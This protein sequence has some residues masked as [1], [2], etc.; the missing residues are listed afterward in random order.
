MNFKTIPAAL[1]GKSGC[2]R[3][4]PG[5]EKG[6]R[7]LAYSLREE[8]NIFKKE[9]RKKPNRG[10]EGKKRTLSKLSQ[11]KKRFDHFAF[12]VQR[13]KGK[14]PCFDWIGF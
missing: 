5:R 12:C 6:G 4:D 1:E 2:Q 8:R 10:E 11:K 3:L 14:Q 9:G 7:R 13:G